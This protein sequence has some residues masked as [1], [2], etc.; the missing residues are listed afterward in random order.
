MFCCQYM[1]TMIDGILTHND[2]ARSDVETD[3]E[4]RLSQA[5]TT[6]LL[7]SY[8]DLSVTPVLAPSIVKLTPQ[9]PITR[10][11]EE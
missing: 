5:H 1:R 4:R 7:V 10:P 2:R 3:N 9:Y 11:I 8:V 6:R